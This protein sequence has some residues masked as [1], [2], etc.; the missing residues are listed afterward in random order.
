MKKFVLGGLLLI[1]SATALACS[2]RYFSLLEKWDNSSIIFIA[3]VTD[4]KTI[5]KGNIEK[6]AEGV[7]NGYFEVVKTFKGNPQSI[8]YLTSAH[9]P[10]CCICS[11]TLKKGSYIVFANNSGPLHLT[12]CSKTI[13]LEFATHAPEVL[14]YLYQKTP[15][16]KFSG[17][18]YAR[19]RLLTLEEEFKQELVHEFY[20]KGKAHKSYVEFNGY[21]LNDGSI[22]FVSLIKEIALD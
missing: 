14:E 9:T 20:S 5:E 10:I 13:P 18:Y 2:C 4:I 16:E 19:K 11:T 21:R 8:P 17:M 15:T 12:Y 22:F 3:N 6:S 7:Q 1:I